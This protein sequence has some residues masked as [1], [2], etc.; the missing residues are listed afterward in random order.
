[1]AN[2]LDNLTDG[3]IYPAYDIIGRILEMKKAVGSCD[4]SVL[5]GV[6]P[7]CAA[8]VWLLRD[9]SDRRIPAGVD[10]ARVSREC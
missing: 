8:D 7:L 6:S 1:M 3:E 4:L 2:Y 5:Y 10:R 9:A